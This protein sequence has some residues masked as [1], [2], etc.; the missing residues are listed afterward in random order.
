MK[1]IPVDDAVGTVLPHDMTKILPGEF[2]GVGFKKDH[3]VRAEDVGESKK[4]ES[5]SSMFLAP[6]RASRRGRCGPEDCGGHIRTQYQMD[7]PKR[8][9]HQWLATS[10]GC[11]KLMSTVYWKSIGL[12]IS[13]FRNH[14]TTTPVDQVTSCCN[15]GNPFGHRQERNLPG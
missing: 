13:R 7:P 2:K 1:T 3:I 15:K 8:G 9:N 11:S 6:T 5:T 12:I 14:Q 10:A 4:W